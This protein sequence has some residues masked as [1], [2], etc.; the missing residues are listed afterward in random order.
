MACHVDMKLLRVTFLTHTKSLLQKASWMGC[1]KSCNCF[2]VRQANKP[3]F[4]YVVNTTWNNSLSKRNRSDNRPAESHFKKLM[5]NI[6]RVPATCFLTSPATLHSISDKITVS[7]IQPLCQ[8]S[9]C[10]KLSHGNKFDCKCTSQAIIYFH[11]YW[12]L[13]DGFGWGF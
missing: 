7:A 10:Q 5:E 9:G 13:K 1:L 8:F 2:S 6:L 4:S 12:S 11:F 3:V